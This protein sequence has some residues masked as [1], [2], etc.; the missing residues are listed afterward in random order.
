MENKYIS[1][2]YENE[3]YAA[4]PILPVVAEQFKRVK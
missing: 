1:M 4:N 2:K 3:I